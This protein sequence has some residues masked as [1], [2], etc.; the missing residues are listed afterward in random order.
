M[1]SSEQNG[2][3]YLGLG[4][5]PTSFAIEKAKARIIEERSGEQF[6]LFTR[7]DKLD[8]AKQK[9]WRF[10]QVT[11]IAGMSGSGKSYF[12]N[13]LRQ[14]FLDRVDITYRNVD[15]FNLNE[16]PYEC[17]YQ[18]ETKDAYFEPHP[19]YGYNALYYPNARLVHYQDVLIHKAINRDCKHKVL[20]VHFGYEMDAADELIR[21]AG[22]V[23]GKSYGYLLS[24][25]W[26]KELK[27]YARLTD[28]ELD[29]CNEILDSFQDRMELYIPTSG[30][31]DQM[32]QTLYKIHSM[33]PDYKVVASI[34]HTLLSKKLNEKSDADLQA[35]TALFCIK[36]RQDFEA[37]M[38][39]LNQLN[40]NIESDDRRTKPALHYP[41]KADIHLGSQIWWACDDVLINHRPKVLGI[42][43]Y[44][45]EKL[46]TTSLIHGAFIK[47]RRGTI[48]NIWFKDDFAN[49][50]ILP[51]TKDNFLV[52]AG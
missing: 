41:G 14:D 29:A 32:Y 1:T 47:A 34:D 22:N 20:C 3:E 52:G 6:G 42:K 9:Y 39:P 8:R 4:F 49:G 28:M 27:A 46:D 31:V 19:Q 50:R 7:W 11:M 12:L 44:G 18:E 5:T 38:L 21:Q 40:Q 2:Q 25:E 37:M 33:Y 24:S 43:S 10:S 45:V 51:A 48:G 17:Y 15:A 23:I 30:N 26:D 16:T 13:M 35:N 36:A